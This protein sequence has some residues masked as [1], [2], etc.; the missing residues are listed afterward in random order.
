MNKTLEAK[1]DA[2]IRYLLCPNYEASRKEELLAELNR[3]GSTPVVHSRKPLKQV[4]ED[5]LTHAGVPSHIKGYKYLALA[6]EMVIIDPKLLYHITKGLYLNVAKE[7]ETTAS[8]AERAMR[9]AIEV[10]FDRNDPN[11]LEG[12]FG[13][14]CSPSRGKLTNA[15]FISRMAQ[16][17]QREVKNNEV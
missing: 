2:I 10:A 9:H 12:L 4:I 15:E 13:H 3:F 11:I 7:C 17:V 1:V 8:R 14:S 5:Y 16:L 6:I